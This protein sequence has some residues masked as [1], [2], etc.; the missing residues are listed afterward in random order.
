MFSVSSLT[1]NY[2]YFLFKGGLL[3]EQ[4]LVYQD[5]EELTPLIESKSMTQNKILNESSKYKD[6]NLGLSNGLL[7][8]NIEVACK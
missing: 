5:S 8:S 7:R 6:P 3:S 1:T 2:F 4:G